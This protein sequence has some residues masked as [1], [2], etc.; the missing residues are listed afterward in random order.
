MLWLLL[1]LS[2]IFFGSQVVFYFLRDHVALFIQF[3]FSIP[4]G[5]SLSTLAY[6]LCSPFLG[7]NALHVMI[8]LGLLV[9]AGGILMLRTHFNKRFLA[10]PRPTKSDILFFVVSL[11]LALYIVPPLYFSEPR[12]VSV[13][14]AGEI[15]EELSLISSFSYGVNGGLGNIFK[16]RHP[17][18]DK[19]VC[20]TRWQSAYHSSMMRVSLASLRLS[21]TVPSFLLFLSI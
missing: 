17:A 4:I 14:V 3:S 20:R 15:H 13:A 2:E 8:H 9:F 6:F 19:C 21:L 12:S 10:F 16:I 5:F 7:M 1:N 11:L 18:C